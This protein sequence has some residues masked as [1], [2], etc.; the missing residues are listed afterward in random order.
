M[1]PNWAVR[2]GWGA[3]KAPTLATFS[4]LDKRTRGSVFRPRGL[5][6]GTYGWQIDGGRPGQS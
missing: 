5:C 1:E 3:P 6:L 2:L 4:R